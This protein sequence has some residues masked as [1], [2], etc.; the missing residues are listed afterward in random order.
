MANGSGQLI[1]DTLQVLIEAD[2]VGHRNQ[3]DHALQLT[4]GFEFVFMKIKSVFPGNP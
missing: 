2:G 3:F 1:P 4:L